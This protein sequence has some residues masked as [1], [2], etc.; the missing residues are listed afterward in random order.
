MHKRFNS[1]NF[2]YIFLNYQKCDD[3]EVYTEIKENNS[4][5]PYFNDIN[6]NKIICFIVE[7]L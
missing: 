2:S 1:N 4:R 5:V 7:K 3:I 6:K